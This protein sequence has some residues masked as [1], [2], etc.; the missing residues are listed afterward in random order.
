[1]D[2]IEVKT[3]FE[4]EQEA[5][6]MAELLLDKRLVACAQILEINSHYIWK[7]E[8]YIEHEYMIIMKTQAKLFKKLENTIK[9]HHSYE[10]AEIIATPICDLSEEYAQWIVENTSQE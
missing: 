4:V 5:I 7:N 1:M 10:V 8:R 3:T 2:F 9:Q 6:D